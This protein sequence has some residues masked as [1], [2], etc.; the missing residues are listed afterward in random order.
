M[1]ATKSKH[2]FTKGAILPQL[3]VFALPIMAANILQ[4]L[5]NAADMIVV[6]M[7]GV[8]N[9][10]GAIGTSTHFFNLFVNLFIGFSVGANVVVARNLGARDDDGVSRAV[11]T[12][13]I[14]SVIFGILGLIF[15]LLLARPILTFMGNTGSL[16]ELAVTYTTICF[17]GMPFLSLTNF[18]VAIFRAKGDSRTPLIVLAVCGLLNVLM[19]LFFVLVMGLSVEGVAL[20]TM[21]SNLLS[22]ATMLFILYRQEDATAL[23]LK[24]LKLSLTTA[25]TIFLIGIP[26]GLQGACFSTSNMLIQSSVVTVN[27]ILVPSGTDYQPIV[28]GNAAAAN[29]EGFVYTTMNAV[30]QAVMTFTS[31]NAGAREYKRLRPIMYY[32]F[33]MNVCIGI[34]LSSII[35]I[36]KEPL[37]ALYGVL[38]GEVGTLEALATY[39][40][41][42]KITLVCLPYFICGILEV[43]T[44]VMRGLGK[45]ISAML[46]TLI[47]T[48]VF[49]IVWIL[50][51]FP[52]F[53]TLESIFIVYP[54]SWLLSAAF[55][56]VVVNM[57]LRKLTSKNKTQN[58]TV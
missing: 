32:G 26:A 6:G 45:S 36:L 18:L 20:A 8:T 53:Y 25:K 7:S 55:T 56:F 31:Q 19:N 57:L 43:L 42:A 41:T 51:V 23:R 10:V 2:N 29:I 11:H 12:S 28:A 21:L 48:C 35:F 22:A 47:G 37:F 5:Y 54:I 52:A 4:M 34:I 27:N 24:K 50:T 17:T 9:A 38:P 46:I 16:L 49:R 40:A 39:A 13:L 14:L 30:Y 15:G 58:E 1:L 3:I 33:L 44:G